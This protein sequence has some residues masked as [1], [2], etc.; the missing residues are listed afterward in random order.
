MVALSPDIEP[1][2]SYVTSAGIDMTIGVIWRKR[3]DDLV[4]SIVG[5]LPNPYWNVPR[6]SDPLRRLLFERANKA[7]AEGCSVTKAA[8]VI[9]AKELALAHGESMVRKAVEAFQAKVNNKVQFERSK[10]G[11]KPGESS[12]EPKSERK[13]PGPKLRFS[14]VAV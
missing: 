13:R 1:P 14:V 2:S 6:G 7:V 11:P 4:Q 8:E 5:A 9:A 12:R 10:R 3:A